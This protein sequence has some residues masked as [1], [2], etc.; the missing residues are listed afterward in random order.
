MPTPDFGKMMMDSLYAGFERGAPQEGKCICGSTFT[1]KGRKRHIQG[2]KHIQFL[3]D[4]PN[5]G[6]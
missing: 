2:N 1:A 6:L 4:N 3:M 5:A